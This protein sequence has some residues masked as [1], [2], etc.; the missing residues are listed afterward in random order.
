MRLV[1]S[2]SAV[3]VFLTLIEEAF[4]TIVPDLD[5][6]MSLSLGTCWAD[7]QIH[8][9][10]CFK[11]FTD[12]S[13]YQTAQEKCQEY[14]AQLAVVKDDDTNDLVA[15]LKGSDEEVWIGLRKSDGIWKWIDDTSLDESFHAWAVGWHMN[16]GRC[17][18][19]GVSAD[20]QNVWKKTDCSRLYSYICQKAV[21]C[22]SPSLPENGNFI[23]SPG[24]VGSLA[25]QPNDVLHFTCNT[26]HNL[27][28]APALTCRADG[29]WSASPP[30]CRVVQ[31]PILTNPANGD[32]SGSNSYGDRVQFECNWGYTLVGEDSLT[33]KD[34]GHWN[35][36]APTCKGCPVADYVSFNGVC[37]KNFSERRKYDGAKQ[38]CAE[39]GGLLAMPKDRATNDFFSDLLSD[40][41]FRWL[42]LSD[43]ISEGNWMFE[44]GRTLTS[45]GFANWNQGEPNGYH[46]ENCAALWSGSWWID[47]SCTDHSFGFICQLDQDC[48][49]QLGMESGAIPDASITASSYYHHPYAPYRAR[50]NGVIDAGAWIARNAGGQWLQVYLGEIKRVTGTI[51]QGRYNYDQ[52]VTSYK[53]QYGVNWT[54]R[55][56]Y[57]DSDGTAMVFPGNRDRNTPVTNLLTNPVDARYVRF[58]P[59]TWHVHISMRA[60]I[61][62]CSINDCRNHLGMESG[63]IPDGSITAS[64]YY[65]SYPPYRARLNRASGAGA[66]MAIYNAV[67]QWLQ[68]DLGELKR[69]TGTIVQGRSDAYQWVTSYKLQYSVDRITWL[70]YAGSDGTEMVFPGNRDRNTPVTNLLTNPVD[71]RYVRFL[72]QTWLRHISMRAEILGC[73]INDC[74]N[75]LGMESGAIP[76]G[77]ITASSYYSSYHPYRARLNRASG[78]GAWIAIY[79]AVGQW[80]QVDLG[81]LKRV[82]GTIVQGRSDAYQW[83]TSYKLQYSVDRITWLTYAGSDGTEMVFAGNRDRNTPVTNLLTNPVDARYVRFLPQTW[84]GHISMR[85]EI[86]GCSIYDCRNQLGMES[87]AIPDGSITASS[88]YSS[89]P[90]YHGRLNG[91]SP[92]GS[93]I[94]YLSAVGQWLQVDL[95]KMTRVT[96]T[97][98]QGRYHYD[99]WVTSY[100]LQ[101]G[102]DGITWLQY[103]GSD[104]TETSWFRHISMRAEILGCSTNVHCN[105]L[106]NPTDGVVSGSNAY[107]SVLTFTCNTG[108]SLDG[109]ATLTCRADGTWSGSPPTCTDVDEC[110]SPNGGCGQNMICTN[111]IGSYLCSC[112]VGYHLETGSSSCEDVDECAVENGGCDQIC[113]NEIGSF[114]CSCG[115]GYVWNADNRQCDDVD[116][117]MEVPGICGHYLAVCTNNIGNFDCTCSRGYAMVSGGCHDVDEC[118]VGEYSCAQHAV[119]QNTD[120]S[121]LCTCKDGFIGD[122]TSCTEIQ[123]TT[124]KTTKTMPTTSETTSEPETSHVNTSPQPVSTS[125]TS[126]TGKSTTLWQ[127]ETTSHQVTSQP[128]D[129]QASTTDS[130]AFGGGD[131]IDLDSPI[132]TSWPTMSTEPQTTE[133]Y[134]LPDFWP[135]LTGLV[136]GQAEPGEIQ[137]Y[138]N[139]DGDEETRLAKALDMVYSQS[140]DLDS[141]EKVELLA[142]AT[143]ILLTS[144]GQLNLNDQ[145]TGGFIVEKMAKSIEELSENG[146]SFPQLR[147]AASAVVDTVSILVEAGVEEDVTVK[148]ESHLLP[149]RK[150]KAYKEKLEEELL[151]K[152]EEQWN[153]VRELMSYCLDA[154]VS[155]SLVIV[156]R[157]RI[158]VDKSVLEGND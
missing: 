44:D 83:V 120:G 105:A 109:A 40:Y 103:A 6:D 88:Y 134:K 4:L 69:V 115:S 17:V 148:D 62:G 141:S 48:R 146:A 73:S 152:K 130:I 93:W 122:G 31:C 143:D 98:I 106:T 121:Y 158:A 133:E 65:S 45:F 2:I 10:S 35:G 30:V 138:L 61:L 11:L 39:D 3:F 22:V 41:E 82:T 28:G 79:N 26:G 19:H 21:Q 110:A 38:R 29:T 52:W 124:V 151:E 155:I 140:S 147:P 156:S 77:S 70:T 96:A 55:V 57:E 24:S 84:L 51:I 89:Y 14:G 85:A 66:W 13:T 64:S 59:Q 16:G 12:A 68:V 33:C 125:V 126:G 47:A 50:L 108:Y 49:N 119:C 102:V 75:H 142:K 118:A 99:Q 136:N 116:E 137:Q 94:A 91:V 53:L 37:Y 60:E 101:Y 90:P 71:A 95:G 92:A 36:N 153:L 67:G 97:I 87:G 25:Y 7:S 15:M 63:A 8:G 149:P 145:A 144:S 74:R 80:L 27:D 20:Y 114:Q 100:K 131:Q 107:G 43:N 157:I 129:T 78:A 128:P 18:L 113:T 123:T 46:N 56:T 5:G 72:P 86:L 135:G 111:T 139:D 58:L 117:C 42:G 127:E 23:A 32:V 76:D 154:V 54:T 9:S 1:K 104:G 132:S 81:E 34:T 150:R 112:L